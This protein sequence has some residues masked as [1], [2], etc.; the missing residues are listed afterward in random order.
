MAGAVSQGYVLRLPGLSVRLQQR[1]VTVALVLAS[2]IIA[3]GLW[4]LAAG[5][6]P[7]ALERV[8]ATL[9]GQGEGGENF[10]VLSLR[11]PRVLTA[12]LAGAAFGV[13]GALLQSLAR[14]PLA[15]PDIIGF[16][17]GAALGAV[18]SVVVFGASGA[19]IAAGAI[20]GGL[21]AAAMVLAASWRNGVAPMRLVLVG[22]GAG[23]FFYAGMQFLLTRSDIF[24]ASAAQAWLTGSLNAR[25]WLHVGVAA[26]GALTLIPAALAL[27]AALERLELGDDLAAALGIRVELARI[28]AGGV[29]V[30]LAAVAVA[31]AGP[32]PFVALAA[33]PLARRMSGASGPTL[34]GAGL[35]GAVIVL[36]A[37][38]AGRLV[39]APV[40]LPAGIFTAVL[41][42]PYLL[43]LLATQIRKGAM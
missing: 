43:W 23:A 42:V 26:L 38:L 20:G 40:Q 24:E 3:L 21:A 31:S 6:F 13:S 15:S 22:I 33:A 16:D 25:V 28:A 30:L 29:A 36:G 2:A 41:G 18:A 9:A 1:S 10:V 19:M 17:A 4:S 35:V 7:L 8:L 37:D 11:L 27:H 12:I 32:L 14:N 39:F 5:D 34:M